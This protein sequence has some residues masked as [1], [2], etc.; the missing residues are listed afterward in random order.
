M[1]NYLAVSQ[2]VWSYGDSYHAGISHF[3]ISLVSK[4]CF[5]EK[6]SMKPTH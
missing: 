3:K 5:Q 2:V 6:A 4:S 1:A